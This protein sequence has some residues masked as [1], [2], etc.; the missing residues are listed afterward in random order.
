M[1]ARSASRTVGAMLKIRIAMSNHSLI[2][3]A[4]H[5]KAPQMTMEVLVVKT[6]T[7]RLASAAHG[8]DGGSGSGGDH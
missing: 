2:E 7:R 1:T 6:G 4:L 3:A 5:S 8:S